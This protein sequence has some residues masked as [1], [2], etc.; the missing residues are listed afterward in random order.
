MELNQAFEMLGLQPGA[1]EAT[2]KTAFRRLAKEAHPDKH[3]G[4]PAATQRFQQINEAYQRL[5]AH[6]SGSA[7]PNV[8]APEPQSGPRPTAPEM[9]ELFRKLRG[10]KGRFGIY[11]DYVSSASYLQRMAGAEFREDKGIAGYLTLAFTYAER[12]RAH[13]L[14]AALTSHETMLKIRDELFIID[15]NINGL[16]S[17]RCNSTFTGLAATM[18]SLDHRIER[19]TDA[20]ASTLRYLR[21][22]TDQ[23][24]YRAAGPQPA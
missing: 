1:D 19:R 23:M 8:T 24:K 10:L 13:T 4:D 5:S 6:Y 9:A 3:A 16:S 18:A 15:N 7:E 21:G 22:E 20:I 2:A 17:G 11:A 14:Y 12:R